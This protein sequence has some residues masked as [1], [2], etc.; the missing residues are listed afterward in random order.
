MLRCDMLSKTAGKIEAPGE[1][2]RILVAHDHAIAREGLRNLLENQPRMEVVGD[3]GDG[4]ELVSMALDLSP[5]VVV[6]SV[7]LEGLNSVE[8]TRRILSS[9]KAIKIIGLSAHSGQEYLEGMLKAGASAFLANDCLFQELVQAIHAVRE[10]R[11]Y[12]APGITTL[13]INEYLRGK[14]GRS[15]LPR[16]LTGREEQVLSL[17][18]EGKKIKGVALEL[19]LSPKTVEIHHRRIKKK[20]GVTSTAELIKYAI[21]EGF[22]NL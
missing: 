2:T 22:T 10:D 20:L 9:S 18:A 5:H 1:T 19:K 3:A 4:R 7:P 17:I 8:A 14:Q 16:G 13:L 21:R 12:L 15:S 6:M 11:L